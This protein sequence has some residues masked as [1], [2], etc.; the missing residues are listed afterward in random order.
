MLWGISNL[1]ADSPETIKALIDH[2]IFP[3]L[4]EFT[5]SSSLKIRLECLFVFN[6]LIVCAHY[7]QAQSVFTNYPELMKRLLKVVLDN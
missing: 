2:E 6:N 1:V 4:T 3:S 5:K 7:K